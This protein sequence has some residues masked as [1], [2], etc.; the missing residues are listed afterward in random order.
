MFVLS[1]EYSL[2]CSVSKKPPS[3]SSFLTIVGLFRSRLQ[4][5]M[6]WCCLGSSG[7]VVVRSVK[8]MEVKVSAFVGSEV[9]SDHLFGVVLQVGCDCFGDCCFADREYL[10]CR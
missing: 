7:L 6:C 5:V 9:Q 3:L 10:E 8:V 1:I 2:L 4:G